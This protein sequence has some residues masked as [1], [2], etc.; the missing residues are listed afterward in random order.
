MVSGNGYSLWTVST[1][2]SPFLIGVIMQEILEEIIYGKYLRKST[3]EAERQVLS[4]DS[5]DDNIMRRFGT[6]KISK[7]KFRESKSAFKPHNRPDFNRLMKLIDAGKIT[8]ILAWH[9]DRLARN[10]IEAAEITWRIRQGLI[11][12]LKFASGFTFENT[13]EG[14][15]MLQMVM[16]QSQYFSAKLSKDV[17][18]GN[19]KKRQMGGLTGKAPEG[20]LHLPIW[21]RRSDSY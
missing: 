8:G 13:P 10:E 6:L 12:D 11:K 14:I 15:M 16:S 2:V 1:T 20:Y 18:R 4:L 17:K 9:P 19:E 5:Q 3:E 21:Q 7:E